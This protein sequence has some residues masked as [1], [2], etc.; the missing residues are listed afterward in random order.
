MT[1]TQFARGHASS[2]PTNVFCPPV[3]ALTLRRFQT[4]ALLARMDG[5]LHQKDGWLKT[6][7]LIADLL[8]RSDAGP[9]QLDLS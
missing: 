1:M 2:R 4:E 7:L 6:Y 5:P 3:D 8:E 9:V